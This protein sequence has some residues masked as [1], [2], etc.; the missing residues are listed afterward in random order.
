MAAAASGEP[1]VDIRDLDVTFA[2]DG[3]DVHAVRDVS[4]QVQPGEVL[5]V[6]GESG[7]GKTVTA[8][9]MLGLSRPGMGVLR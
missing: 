8:R 2:T 3:G 1:A 9:T 5:A 7:S 6:V 4:L